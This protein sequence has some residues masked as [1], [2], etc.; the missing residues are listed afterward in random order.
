MNTQ[1]NNGYMLIFRGTDWCKG[2]SP[3]EMQQVAGEWM[4][5]FK[6]LTDQGKAIAGNPLQPEGK[7]VS[8]KGGRLVADGPFAESKEAIGGYF[9]LQVGSMD[10]AVAIA[11]GCPGLPYGA[12][13]EVRPVAEECPMAAEART[14]AEVAGATAGA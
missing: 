13:V 3:E 9:L 12:R 5:W 6:R 14:G 8:G 7:I 10:E 1:L 2:L 4:A 11:R